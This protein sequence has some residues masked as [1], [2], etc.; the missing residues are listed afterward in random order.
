[1]HQGRDELT[2]SV[3][4]LK[5]APRSSF[6]LA[7]A[8]IAA[9]LDSP[10]VFLPS[11]FFASPFELSPLVSFFVGLAELSFETSALEVVL[12]FPEAGFVPF[13]GEESVVDLTGALV[14]VDPFFGGI[15]VSLE[16]FDR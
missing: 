2:S 11:G 16:L 15:L 14:V 4:H 7:D 12:V 13:A 1:M 8:I 6:P 5:A 10:G 3:S 9:V